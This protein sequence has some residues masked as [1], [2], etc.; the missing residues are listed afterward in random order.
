MAVVDPDDRLL[1]ARNPAWPAGRRS[2]LAGFVEPGERLEG[3]VAREVFEE[4]GVVV[5]DVRYVASQPWPFPASLM[6]GF[7]ARAVAADLTLDSVEIAEAEWYTRAEVAAGV[8]DGSLGLP[9]RTSIARRLLEDW[10]GARLEPPVEVAFH[11]P[12][13][14]TAVTS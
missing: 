6:L 10:Y 13:G 12:D 3:A 1:L 11:R 9:G 7:T 5:T 8:A 4:V 14:T 2:V